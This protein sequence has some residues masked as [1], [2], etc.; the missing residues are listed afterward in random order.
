MTLTAKSITK[1]AGMTHGRR[2]TY[3]GLDKLAPPCF[4]DRHSGAVGRDVGVLELGAVEKE[5]IVTDGGRIV[6][7]GGTVKKVETMGGGR[8]ERETT[9]G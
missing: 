1:L 3:P 6:G 4:H 2:T 5:L 7:H 8:E 9:E